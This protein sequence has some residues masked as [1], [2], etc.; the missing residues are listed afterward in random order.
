MFNDI[1]YLL[2]I[3]ISEELVGS[4]MMTTC[5]LF[6]EVVITAM[7]LTLNLLLVLHMRHNMMFVG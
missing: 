7:L 1:E 4:D 5:G 6:L 2:Q 3:L